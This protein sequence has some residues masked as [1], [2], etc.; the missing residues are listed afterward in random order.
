MCRSSNATLPEDGGTIAGEPVR[1]GA[2][3]PNF[4]RQ[5]MSGSS[6]Q[7]SIFAD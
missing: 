4:R 3:L 5:L 1:G 7:D 6:A 2:G